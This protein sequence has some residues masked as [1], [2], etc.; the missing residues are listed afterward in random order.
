MKYYALSVPGRGGPQALGLCGPMC[1]SKEQAAKVML[2]DISG[3]TGSRHELCLYINAPG[4][5]GQAWDY[6]GTSH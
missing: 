4:V 1:L 3:Y 6:L 5:M 2:R